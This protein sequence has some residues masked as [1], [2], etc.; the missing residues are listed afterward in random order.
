M[1][2]P[3]FPRRATRTVHKLPLS[4]LVPHHTYHACMY[5]SA[6]GA[7]KSALEVNGKRQGRLSG[8]SIL[9]RM[10]FEVM[11]VTYMMA[12]EE[13]T[14]CN[15]AVVAYYLSA[16]FVYQA[17]TISVSCMLTIHF[18]V[19]LS[20][21]AF[22]VEMEVSQTSAKWFTFDEIFLPPLRPLYLTRFFIFSHLPLALVNLR[23][24]ITDC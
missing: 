3:A 4:L 9:S 6:T 18:T 11:N 12:I 7:L 10:T 13:E 16:A 22:K 14:E 2:V 24:K 19:R 8:A 5:G 23:F 21:F 17:G 1:D 15:L 20:D